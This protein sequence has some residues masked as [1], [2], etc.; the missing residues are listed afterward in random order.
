MNTTAKWIVWV[1]R[2]MAAWIAVGSLPSAAAETG[3]P[4]IEHYTYAET[5]GSQVIPIEYVI[6]RGEQVVIRVERADEHFYNRCATSGAT[7]EWNY[8]GDNVEVHAQ[9]DGRILVIQGHRQG[10]PFQK[11]HH[12]DDAPWFQPLSYALQP[13]AQSDRKALRFWLIRSDNLEP[14]KLKAVRSGTEKIFVNGRNYSSSR[15]DVSPIGPLSFVWHGSYWFRQADGVFL[16][17][18]GGH[19]LSGPENTLIRIRTK[20]D[21]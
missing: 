21:P 20:G 2:W 5:T 8:R 3:R 4:A 7:V 16:Q 18:A 15:I 1:G 12:I 13:F 6:E 17:Y 10:K 11:R 14:V 19:L 9:R